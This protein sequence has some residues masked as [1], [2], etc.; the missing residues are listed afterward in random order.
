V[1]GAAEARAP[2]PYGPPAADTRR[3]LFCTVCVETGGVVLESAYIDLK[4]ALFREAASEEEVEEA[5][6]GPAAAKL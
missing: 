5:G 2:T 1:V 6:G 3:V 4:A